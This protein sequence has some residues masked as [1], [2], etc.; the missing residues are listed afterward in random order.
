MNLWQLF[1]IFLRFGFLA[2]GGPVAQINMIREELV[3]KRKWIDSDKF[4]RV[5]AI[6]QAL[7]GPEA[8]ELCVYFG[9]TQRGRIGAIVAGLGFMLPGFCLMVLLSWLYVSFGSGMLVWFVGVVP[10]VAALIVR[11]THRIAGHVLHGTS[12]ICA[13]AISVILTLLSVHFALVFLICILW[14]ILWT[15]NYRKAAIS[16]AVIVVALFTISFFGQNNL[17]TQAN[18]VPAQ[19]GLFIEGLKAG[20]LS[21][22]GAY[23]VIPFLKESMIGVYSGITH[24]SFYDGIALS[25]VIPAPLVIFGTFL[26][27]VANGFWGA[28]LMTAG[29]FLP[30][31][32]FTLFG[33]KPL[34]KLLENSALHLALD[35]IAAAVVGMLAVTALDIFMHSVLLVSLK[36]IL[37]FSAALT[38]LFLLKKKWTIP[39]VVILSGLVG[40]LF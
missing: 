14:Q 21:F 33:H 20:L 23:T 15:K 1:K 10:A 24:Q 3:E 9:M 18:E 29:I 8:H 11:A 39:L 30:A 22:G 34:E 16:F 4:K 37:I 2:W 17:A 25:S 32:S 38:A 13:A 6:Y 7:P 26:G 12:L 31:F 5:L 27:F 19:H 35:A 40:L 28:F 36:N